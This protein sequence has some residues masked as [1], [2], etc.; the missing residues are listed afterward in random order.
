MKRFV[1]LGRDFSQERG[2]LTPTMKVERKAI[3]RAFA[4]EL[5]RLYTEADAGLTPKE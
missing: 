5:D 3:E 1:V 2:E 4:A